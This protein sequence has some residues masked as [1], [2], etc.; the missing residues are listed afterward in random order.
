MRVDLAVKANGRL[1]ATYPVGRS[2][3][4]KQDSVLSPVLLLLVLDP[5]L[6]ELQASWLGL[7][8]TNFY[9]GGFLYADD[10]RTLTSSK[11]DLHAGIQIDQST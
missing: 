7:S 4:G 5:L 6:R 9:A 2:G 3:G 1:S 10:V 8:V 11:A